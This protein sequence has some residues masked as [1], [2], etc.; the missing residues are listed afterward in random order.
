M[1][2]SLPLLIT[3]RKVEILPKL[4]QQFDRKNLGKTVS[5]LIFVVDEFD[6]QMFIGDMLTEKMIMNFN[7]HSP[8]MEYMID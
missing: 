1:S 7:V 8:S 5:N 4:K 6:L 3:L 2:N